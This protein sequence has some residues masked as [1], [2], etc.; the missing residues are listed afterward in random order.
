MKKTIIA[1][2][3]STAISNASYA[4]GI[5]V[6]DAAGLAQA[7]QTV[8]QLKQQIDQLKSLQSQ[9]EGVRNMGS[10]LNIPE[11]RNQLPTEWQ[12]VY[13]DVKHGNIDGLSG[14]FDKLN[15]DEAVT[16][17]KSEID[18]LKKRRWD[19][20]LADKAMGENAYNAA[21]QRLSNIEALGAKINTTQD[22]KA[23]MD[24]ISR[25]SQE[26]AL[27][28]N[29]SARMQLMGQLQLAED[30]ML[31]QKEEKIQKAIWDVNKPMPRF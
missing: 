23:S 29:E 31:A 19:Q 1:I 25:V 10:L 24:L 12:N 17:T 14:A 26:Q 11:L 15:N 6:F 5:P 4:T 21:L 27:V 22:A 9:F 2:F 18:A 7:L 8:Q 13:D 20:A 3:L 30:R 28:Q 16:G